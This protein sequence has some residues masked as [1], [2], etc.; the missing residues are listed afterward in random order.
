MSI[1]EKAKSAS[2]I[3]GVEIAFNGELLPSDIPDWQPFH[4]STMPDLDFTKTYIGLGT[5]SFSEESSLSNAGY[6]YKQKVQIRFPATDGLRAERIALLH[7]AKF[8]KV[9]L[10]N[11]L[12]IVV[13]R[14]D[15]KQNSR[16]KIVMK[17]NVQ[18]AEIEFETVSIFPSGY[19]PSPKGFFLPSLIPLTL[20]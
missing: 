14:N 4:N 3:C 10:N 9:I 2:N 18:L 16:P 7:K 13:G 11:G 8:I 17:S 1:L 12:D 20:I 15:Y 5:V 19:V 6:I